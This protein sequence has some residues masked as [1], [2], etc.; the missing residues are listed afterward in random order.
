MSILH[1]WYVPTLAFEMFGV[2]WTSDGTMAFACPPF[3]ETRVMAPDVL[4][5]VV[6]LATT[7]AKPVDVGKGCVQ[8]NS[9]RFE[10]HRVAL[11][12]AAFPGVEWRCEEW[13]DGVASGYVDGALVAVVQSVRAG[14]G[15]SKGAKCPACGGRKGPVCGECK[16]EGRIAC[17]CPDC[18]DLHSRSCPV[19]DELGVVGICKTCNGTG[20]WSA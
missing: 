14:F 7:P 8:M 18:D 3:A 15:E 19:C 13:Q 12:E 10:A 11:I 17:R 2:A 4:R 16:G 1:S 20:R 5:S 6:E 9:S